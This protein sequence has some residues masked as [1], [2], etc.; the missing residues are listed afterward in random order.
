MLSGVCDLEICPTMMLLG[1]RSWYRLDWMVEAE[2][3]VLPLSDKTTLRL[4]DRIQQSK[5]RQ[6]RMPRLALLFS[7]I[8]V[9]RT[10]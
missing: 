2:A 7:T 6:G 10:T 5:V 3:P 4:Q 9:F 8:S 1:G